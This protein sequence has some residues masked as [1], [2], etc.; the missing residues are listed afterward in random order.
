MTRRIATKVLIHR[1]SNYPIKI[2]KQAT[3]GRYHLLWPTY[4]NQI[5]LDT[6]DQVSVQI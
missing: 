4:A 6:K 3:R 2:L 1:V 5:S